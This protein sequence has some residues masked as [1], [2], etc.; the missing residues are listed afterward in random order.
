MFEIR[1]ISFGGFKSPVEISSLCFE[2]KLESGSVKLSIRELSR[3]NGKS[4]FARIILL[5]KGF[6]LFLIPLCF[7]KMSSGETLGKCVTIKSL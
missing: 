3:K 6:V 2:V 1:R 5:H 4:V 7:R